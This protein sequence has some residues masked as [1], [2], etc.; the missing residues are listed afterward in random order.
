MNE[1]K[2]ISIQLEKRFFPEFDQEKATKKLKMKLV[3]FNISL[4]PISI[5][6]FRFFY[7]MTCYTANKLIP[8]TALITA[9]FIT[10]FFIVLGLDMRELLQDFGASISQSIYVRTSVGRVDTDLLN[11]GFFL[12][13]FRF[14]Y[15]ASIKVEDKTN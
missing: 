3:Y 2:S 10:V 12:F 7:I 13:D 15:L 6:I 4:L 8:I 14:E 9:I 11:V 1:N 5:N